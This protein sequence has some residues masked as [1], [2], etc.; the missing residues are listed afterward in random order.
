M[1]AIRLQS[2]RQLAADDANLIREHVPFACRVVHVTA[3]AEAIG[4]GTDFTDVDVTVM[5]GAVDLL[6]SRIPVVNGSALAAPLA[7]TLSATAANLAL[8]AGD[9]LDLDADMTGGSTPTID[10]LFAT[11]W[12]VRE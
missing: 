4:G 10:G 11:V 8:A 12:V 3:G 6:A 2:G 7:G 9:V 5:N 1:V